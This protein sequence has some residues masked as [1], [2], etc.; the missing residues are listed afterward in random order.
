MTFIAFIYENY[1]KKKQF[2]SEKQT[3]TQYKSNN[4]RKNSLDGFLYMG[5]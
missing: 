1:E 5:R 3:L 2:W 4:I